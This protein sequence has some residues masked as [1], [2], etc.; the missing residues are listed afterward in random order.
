MIREARHAPRFGGTPTQHPAPAPARGQHSDEIVGGLGLDA[1]ALRA[2]G[3][4][5]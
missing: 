1:A 2:S 5:F 3:A 4:I